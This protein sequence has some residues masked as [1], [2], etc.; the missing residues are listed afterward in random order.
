[1]NNLLSNIE[2]LDKMKIK[3]INS[4]L[5]TNIMETLFHSIMIAMMIM[6]SVIMRLGR[7]FGQD[8]RKTFF[9]LSMTNFFSDVEDHL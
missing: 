4:N 2:H 9:G 6:M 1:M 3:T 5:L 7:S 8:T